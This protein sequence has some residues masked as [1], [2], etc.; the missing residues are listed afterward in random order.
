MSDEC[1]AAHERLIEGLARYIARARAYVCD[2]QPAARAGLESAYRG[3]RDIQACEWPELESAL[4]A[5]GAAAA[6]VV[7][8]LEHPAPGGGVDPR[9]LLVAHDQAVS[10]MIEALARASMLRL[11]VA[12]PRGEDACRR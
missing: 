7:Q 11:E 8:A 4:E 1:A 2:P 12:V 3:V 10:R 6:R 9:P 5:V